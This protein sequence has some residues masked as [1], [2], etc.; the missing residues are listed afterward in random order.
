[1]DADRGPVY[2]G[3]HDPGAEQA[4]RGEKRDWPYPDHLE[5]VDLLVYAHRAELGHDPGAH[6]GAHDVAKHV[7]DHLAQVTPR[8][9]DAR[10]SRSSLGTCEVSAFDPALESQDE[11]HP[12]DH[13]RASQDQDPRLAQCLAEEVKDSAVEDVAEDRAAE[14]D[15]VAERGGP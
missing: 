11:H 3:Q 9:E 12:P 6:L 10:V 5:R 15:D 14:P 7:G 1:A 8:R 4:R 13:E 2:E